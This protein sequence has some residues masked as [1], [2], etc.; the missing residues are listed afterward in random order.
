MQH[1]LCQPRKLQKIKIS[2]FPL[3]NKELNLSGYLGL[4]RAAKNAVKLSKLL[5]PWG[6]LGLIS[7]VMRKRWLS[8][9]HTVH[10]F[11]LCWY[12]LQKSSFALSGNT[13]EPHFILRCQAPRPCCVCRLLFCTKNWHY[14]EKI[15]DRV[16][17]FNLHLWDGHLMNLVIAVLILYHFWLL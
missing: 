16:Y 14:E 15:L 6:A 13:I 17:S 10:V 5:L 12:S 4:V 9:F 7:M 1:F 11:T 8:E 3:N 2:Q